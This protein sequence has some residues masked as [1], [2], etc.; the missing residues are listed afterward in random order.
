M[1]WTDDNWIDEKD[2]RERGGTGLHAGRTLYWVATIFAALIV[3]FAVADF[4]ISWA[5]GTPIVRV[6][7][8]IAA[9]AV[10]LVGRIC[11]A[12]LS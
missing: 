2:W 4:L 3:V 9:A 12:L 8:F 11:R 5:Q 6:V 1:A 10:W 7:A